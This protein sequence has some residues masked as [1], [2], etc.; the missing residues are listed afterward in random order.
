MRWKDYN[1]KKKL[2]ISFLIIIAI[3]IGAI[4]SVFIGI[5]TTEKVSNEIANN[6]I[7]S[8]DATTK[9]TENW[10]RSTG[11]MNNFYNSKNNLYYFL[12]K[13]DLK[14]F[15]LA[16]NKTNS[17]NKSPKEKL[18]FQNISNKLKKVKE[19]RENY[20]NK[21]NLFIK[22]YDE[23]KILIKD[24]NKDNN[25]N[26]LKNKIRHYNRLLNR[27]T[28]SKRAYELLK[29][30]QELDSFKKLN[31]VNSSKEGKEIIS[32]IQTVINLFKETQKSELRQY[33]ESKMLRI[34]IRNIA[35]HNTIKLNKLGSEN[36]EVVS[37]Q[38]KTLLIFSIILITISIIIAITL[39]RAISIPISNNIKKAVEISNGN[40][41]VTFK[42]KNNDEIG[43]LSKA[44][45]TMVK[46]IKKIIKELKETSK[47]ISEYSDKIKDD[48]IKLSE[49]SN[50]QA[51]ASE[52][53][54][55]SL[56]EI[57]SNIE[58]NS[59][60]T[61]L[62][63]DIAT[64]ASQLIED[65]NNKT[66]IAKDNINNIISKISVIGDIAFKTNLLAINASVEAANGGKFGKG[67]SV[68]ANEVSKLADQSNVSATEI[69]KLSKVTLFSTKDAYNNIN[70]A[71][72]QIEK[73]STL[74]KN[75]AQASK[76][77]VSS[78]DSISNSMY[79]LNEDTQKNVSSTDKISNYA[80]SLKAQASRL[81]KAVN[82][83]TTNE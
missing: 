70:E 15:E 6:A 5:K 8:I 44:L 63:N 83:F 61:K 9:M 13:K 39:T 30:F 38:K 42:I 78:V 12:A 17:L 64:K 53:I 37:N 31:Y 33:E 58:Q 80:L 67:F 74:I 23:L 2:N 16:L 73:T 41:D 14:S 54:S 1:I 57:H 36:I 56:E 69:N 18:L 22:T 11:N 26:L 52:D 71:T 3:T 4:V 81:N 46:N 40:L 34:K 7:P 49:S 19:Y 62:T 43:Q 28:T 51:A 72:K 59:E 60:N 66:Q 50:R 24:F 27:H 20:F 25:N 79:H 68:V 65:G 48:T 35:T 45:N 76:E 29:V 47:L 32:K 75:I 10:E 77:Q 55:A 21:K 82:I